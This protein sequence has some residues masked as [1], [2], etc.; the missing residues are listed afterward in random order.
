M[1]VLLFRKDFLDLCEK[2]GDT[3]SM[4][5]GYSSAGSLISDLGGMYLCFD[6]SLLYHLKIVEKIRV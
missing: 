3:Y 2:V 1:Y 4:S 5:D 6:I